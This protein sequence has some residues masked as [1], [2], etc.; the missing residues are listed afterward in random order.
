[1]R[2]QGLIINSSPPGQ[3]GR[4]FAEDI[5][6]CLFMNEKAL[7]FIQILLKF[8]PKGSTDNKQALV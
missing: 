2:P 5:F 8:V 3:S 7:I 4:H 6:K 1:M